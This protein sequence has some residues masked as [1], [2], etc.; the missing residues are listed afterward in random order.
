MT[1]NLKLTLTPTDVTEALFLF[2]ESKGF[3]VEGE[4]DG[5]VQIDDTVASAGHST[6]GAPVFIFHI[7]PKPKE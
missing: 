1:E 6:P 5:V 4:F 2:M 3:T 7:K